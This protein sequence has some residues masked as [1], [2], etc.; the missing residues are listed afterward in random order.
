[1]NQLLP[2]YFELA[3]IHK[4]I[5]KLYLAVFTSPEMPS[6]YK[7]LHNSLLLFFNVN[8]KYLKCLEET[9]KEPKINSMSIAERFFDVFVVVYNYG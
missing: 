5:L 1:M 3:T 4:P 8:R 9:F 6:K 7:L 2:E